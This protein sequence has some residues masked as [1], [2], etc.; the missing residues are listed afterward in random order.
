[1]ARTRKAL[2]AKV[3]VAHLISAGVLAGVCPR[4]L[5]EEVLAG[6]GKA[7]QRERLLHGDPGGRQLRVEGGDED[8]EGMHE[9]GADGGPD[10]ERPGRAPP[11][12][13]LVPHA[14]AD[15]GRNGAH[16]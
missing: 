2:P 5:I 13:E 9:D 12:A 6:T 1:M 10:R 15:V 8:G 11:V 14:E 3:D 7:S 16:L 4:A